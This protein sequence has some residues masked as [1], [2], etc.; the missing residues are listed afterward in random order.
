MYTTGLTGLHPSLK[1]RYNFA[2]L[3][4]HKEDFECFT[5]WSFF[6]T[7]HGKGPID[8]IGGEVKRSVWREV[9]KGKAVFNDAFGF[10]Q[11][12]SKLNAKINILYVSQTDIEG[13]TVNLQKRWDN[14]K[15]VVGTQAFHFIKPDGKDSV[16]CGK[17]SIFTQKP[18]EL[19]V[20]MILKEA[21]V[22]E[23]DNDNM[24]NSAEHE[25]SAI[26]TPGSFIMVKFSTRVFRG[27]VKSTEGNDFEVTFLRAKD[28]E[29]KI[30][31][32]PTKE[33]CS[34][35]ERK[36]ILSVVDGWVMDK[37]QKYLFSASLPVTE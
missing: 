20:V 6:A 11:V 14:S 22:S 18:H 16:A 25:L 19:K 17:N 3:V 28:D 10:Y 12:A 15:T 27:Q 34:W 8:G 7:S 24:H 23:S 37:R 2:N 5:D 33:D 13:L 26:P 31:S 36:E 29:H 32:F 4:H 9:L 21:I 1:N 35:V 30:F